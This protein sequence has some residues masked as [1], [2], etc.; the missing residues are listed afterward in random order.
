[1][2][3]LAFAKG[4]QSDWRWRIV[5]YAGEM[6]EESPRTFPTI[7][8]AVAEGTQRLQQMDAVDVSVRV[9]PFGSTSYLRGR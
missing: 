7:A 9:N 2:R 3:V 5:N 1:M 4:A 8:A 6:I